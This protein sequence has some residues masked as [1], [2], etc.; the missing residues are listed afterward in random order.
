MRAVNTRPVSVHIH[1]ASGERLHRTGRI[2]TDDG[3]EDVVAVAEV[4]L[5]QREFRWRSA[6]QLRR[7]PPARASKN[8]VS[9]V[10]GC[11]L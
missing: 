4:V 9:I 1:N 8:G 6:N 3:V 11:L 5:Q 2:R 7:D 10:R